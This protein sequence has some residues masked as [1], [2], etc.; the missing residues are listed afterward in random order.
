MESSQ[1]HRFQNFVYS[2]VVL[3]ITLLC[4]SQTFAQS[5]AVTLRQNV[6][7]YE[8]MHD[9]SKPS[10]RLRNRVQCEPFISNLE[11]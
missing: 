8:D 6:D 1:I 10:D 3:C 2:L 9:M 7:S 5:P 11:I 4:L